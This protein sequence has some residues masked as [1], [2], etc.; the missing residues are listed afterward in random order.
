MFDADCRCSNLTAGILRP[1][2]G[3]LMP[4][5]TRIY[6]PLT[7][8]AWGNRRSTS[9]VHSAVSWSSLTQEDVEIIAGAHQRRGSRFSAASMEVTPSA[10][11]AHREAGHGGWRT[12]GRFA[13]G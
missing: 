3:I 7:R 13:G 1:H 6:L 4:S 8:S 9:E 2:L 10:F 5:P 11:G 12:T